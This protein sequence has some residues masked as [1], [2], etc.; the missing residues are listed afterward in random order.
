[1]PVPRVVR[2][3]SIPAPPDLNESEQYAAML[4]AD[5]EGMR[6]PEDDLIALPLGTP[7]PGGGWKKGQN[8]EAPGSGNLYTIYTLSP[9]RAHPSPKKAKHRH[10]G[11]GPIGT[12]TNH[13]VSDTGT[14]PITQHR[15]NV[16][17]GTSPESS[18]QAAKGPA[19]TQWL[20][21]TGSNELTE[22]AEA[23]R[24][25]LGD[26]GATEQQITAK[27]QDGVAAARQASLRG[28]SDDPRVT[29]VMKQV[30]EAAE[31]IGDMRNDSFEALLAQEERSP[32][33]VS[34]EQFKAQ[35]K[36]VLSAERERKLLG[37]SDD[38]ATR[39]KAMELTVKAIGIVGDR[40]ADAVQKLIEQNKVAP[41]SVS[42]AQ[43]STAIKDL[44]AIVRE[45]QLLGVSR[46][47]TDSALAS[48]A[49]VMRILVKQKDEACRKLIE[50]KNSSGGVTDQQIQQ[51]TDELNK[52]KEEARRLGLT[53]ID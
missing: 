18:L 15:P 21:A 22:A 13:P 17:T 12:K 34:D 52:M 23:L 38:S 11:R 9:S 26:P 4:R 43:F 3:P 37:G 2:D 49:E 19:A 36:S 5:R 14:M 7:P 51:A 35:I 20:G 41:G 53:N 50:Q 10:P 30:G 47:K 28:G 40:K 6:R 27:V 24:Q 8:V 42:E 39:S 1:M 46:P 25:V 33:S 31:R 48:V 32:G 45:T 16:P 44:L 29:T